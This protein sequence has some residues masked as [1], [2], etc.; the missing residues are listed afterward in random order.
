MIAMSARAALETEGLFNYKKNPR[1]ETCCVSHCNHP[2]GSRKKKV[3]EFWF[4]HKC[5]Q[6]RWRLKHPKSSA[7]RLL[8]DHALSRGIEFAL[9]YEYFLGMMDAAAAWNPMAETHGEMVTI[10][11]IDA[12][13]G[14]VRGNVRVLSLSANVIKGNKERYLPAHVQAVLARK[15]VRVA[16][17]VGVLDGVEEEELCPF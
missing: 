4:C 9:P 17:K 13:K 3:G 15:R 12:T 7:Y 6:Q 10:D 14:Y 1:P 8:K 11:R 16:D 5:W 2:A